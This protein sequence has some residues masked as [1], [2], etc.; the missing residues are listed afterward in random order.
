[1]PQRLVNLAS[2]APGF[3]GLNKQQSGDVLPPGWATVATNC[4][5]DTI[6]R[7]S[8]R[9]GTKKQHSSAV[10]TDIG[11]AYEYID[12]T[13]GR[14][15]IFAADNK[16]YK[17]VG[18][19]VTDISGTITTPTAND[20]QFTNFNGKCIG[21]QAS[22]DPIVLSTTGGT[23][24]DITLVG[25]NQPSQPNDI[26]AGFGRLWT[27]EGTTLY[28]SDSLD[29]TAWNAALNLSTVWRHGEDEGIAVDEFN[30]LLLIFGRR[31]IAIYS[32]AADPTANTFVLVDNI[33]N[34]GCIA[35]DSIVS[36]GTD[37]LFLSYTGVRSLQRT[38]Q[39]GSSPLNDI[40]KNNRNYLMGFYSESAAIKATYNEF[41]RFYLL[42]FPTKSKVF[43][44]DTLA[45]LEDGSY[46]MTEWDVQHDAYISTYDSELWIAYNAFMCKY[47][48]YTDG[49][50]SAG[51]AGATYN[52][53]FEGPW[54]D[55]GGEVENYLKIPKKG[56]VHFYAAETT[57]ILYKWAFDYRDSYETRQVTTSTFNASE[58][59]GTVTPLSLHEY[60]TAEYGSI[61]A[62][63]EQKVNLAQNGRI[64]KFG[65]EI[66]E[67]Q[68]EFA[69]QR[70][71]M[72]AK[73][74]KQVV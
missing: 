1:M 9:K 39:D 52:Y 71:D 17:I 69:L 64:V 7:L 50:T 38:I 57:T 26:F 66:A 45:P 10:A 62:F 2:S 12:G 60:G 29:E 37:I 31:N 27:I 32:G 74:G 11:S 40:S 4:V 19:T 33:S 51:V 55:F 14:L 68:G 15:K 36:I 21:F 59:S 67:V 30:G 25:S 49:Q 42:S 16:I 6:G 8:A 43:C 46:R 53:C 47:E 72:Q 3:F 24:A 56:S 20:W 54:N 70:I 41:N 48:D 13:G 65:C 63:Q 22:H 35:R 18:S 73:I 5:F 23:F 61:G 58:Y 28:Y 34:I 44:F